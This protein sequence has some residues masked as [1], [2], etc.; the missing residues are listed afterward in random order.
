MDLRHG[1]TRLGSGGGGEAAAG[2]TL[3]HGH[4]GYALPGFDEPVAQRLDEGGLAGARRP[5]DAQTKRRRRRRCSHGLRRPR[6]HRMLPRRP[7]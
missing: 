3:T 5:C 7:R 1:Y 4:D 2:R 6:P